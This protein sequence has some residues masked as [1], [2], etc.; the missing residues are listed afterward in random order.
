MREWRNGDCFLSVM[1]G[2]V[3]LETAGSFNNG[4]YYTKKEFAS[5]AGQDEVREYFNKHVLREA[6]AALT[7]ENE[8]R[9][10]NGANKLIITPAMVY[11][12]QDDR[13]GGT[14]NGCTGAEF[15][16]GMN[17]EWVIEVMGRDI[18]NEALDYLNT[19]S[20]ENPAPEK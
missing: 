20:K 3:F 12:G 11:I 8:S 14:G 5:G 18:L 13:Y 6:L 16:N 17:R 19:L 2:R 7:L 15:I 4:T 1:E 10:F 9:W